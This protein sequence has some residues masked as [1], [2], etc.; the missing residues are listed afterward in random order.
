MSSSAEVAPVAVLPDAVVADQDPIGKKPRG[1]GGIVMTI[2]LALAAIFWIS[3]LALLVL[4]AVRPLSDFI[5][6]GPLSWPDVFTLANFGD[7][8]RIGNFASTYRN[9]AILLILKVPVGCSSRRC[10][11]SRWP[12]CGSGSA[13]PSCTRCS[14]G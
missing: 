8:W 4:T 5:S 12:S 6:N 1:K 11:P 3:P 14:S 9:S 2:V 10:S 13:P 7:A